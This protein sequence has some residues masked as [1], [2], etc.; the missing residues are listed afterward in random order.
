MDVLNI[1]GVVGTV[2]G[3]FGTFYGIYAA[4]KNG[5]K[6]TFLF[7]GH[8]SYIHH[9][10]SIDI[11][12]D[13]KTERK[14]DYTVSKP[15]GKKLLAI[16]ETKQR[17][18]IEF[19]LESTETIKSLKK[20][21]F[22]VSV[23]FTM[24]YIVIYLLDVQFIGTSHIE[25][26]LKINNSSLTHLYIY[27]SLF[28]L[29]YCSM[30]WVVS[31]FYSRELQYQAEVRAYININKLTNINKKLLSSFG[32]K[33][34]EEFPVRTISRMIENIRILDTNFKSKRYNSRIKYKPKRKILSG[35]TIFFDNTYFKIISI[36]VL[37]NIVYMVLIPMEVN[38][39]NLFANI[40]MPKFE[41]TQSAA[42]THR[43]SIPYVLKKKFS[44]ANFRSSKSKN[45]R[46]II[47]VIRRNEIFYSY[48]QSGQRWWRIQTQD[49]KVGYIHSATIRRH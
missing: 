43:F 29:L 22:G 45:N 41:P 7:T 3:A 49:G 2:L 13:A 44:K 23:L 15:I 31:S 46:N 20:I 5:S 1:I 18:L 48:N 39:N 26:V 28:I 40:S 4:N 38:K 27:S 47:R 8:S 35:K 9:D 34:I 17:E 32:F 24:T 12:I 42:P 30:L 33:K 19:I 10:N 37:V 16:R 11:N 25:S 14:Y 21:A 36:V 6:P